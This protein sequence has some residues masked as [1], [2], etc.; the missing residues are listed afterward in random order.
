MSSSLK[1]VRRK[2]SSI[3]MSSAI[4]S[5]VCSKYLAVLVLSLSIPLFIQSYTGKISQSTFNSPHLDTSSIQTM[6]SETNGNLSPRTPVYFLGI[7]GPNFIENTKHPAYAQLAS[8]GHEITTKVK[9][10]AVVVFSAH[11][12]SSPNKI[13]INVG[14]QVDIIFMIFMAFQHITTSTN[15]QTRAVGRLSKR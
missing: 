7:G 12:Q 5:A 2:D 4:R 6:T 13:E 8:I 1:F 15:I 3:V 10:K 14:E 11:W 9:P